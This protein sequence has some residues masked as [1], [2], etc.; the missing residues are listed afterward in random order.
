M[1]GYGKSGCSVHKIC[2]IS[3]SGQDKAKITVDCL[4]KGIPPFPG[5]DSYVLLFLFSKELVQRRGRRV[6]RVGQCIVSICGQLC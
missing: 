4:Y 2:N 1:I 6:S 3:E 5:P